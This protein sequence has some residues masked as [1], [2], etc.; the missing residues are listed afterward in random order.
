M[1]FTV[2]FRGTELV[3]AHRL[4][5]RASG[6]VDGFR[7][8]LDLLSQDLVDMTRQGAFDPAFRL[9]YLGD[10]RTDGGAFVYLAGSIEPWRAAQLRSMMIPQLRHL[11]L[12]LG[13][14][15]ACLDSV[16]IE[17]HQLE[18]AGYEAITRGAWSFAV[19]GQSDFLQRA[20]IQATLLPGQ[21]KGLCEF[22]NSAMR[23]DRWGTS[24]VPTAASCDFRDGWLEFPL[25]V[26]ALF[27]LEALHIWA[28]AYWVDLKR[29]E[30]F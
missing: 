3:G 29:V 9:D 25:P 6:S 24:E 11:A 16:R 13:A 4:H 19:E 30:C 18:S 22:M 1:S 17:S 23:A 10:D 8:A 7:I 26:Y 28:L 27:V 14:H 5:I 20:N 15:S 2:E 12:S 21:K